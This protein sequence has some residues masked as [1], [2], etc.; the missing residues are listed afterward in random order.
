M[1]STIHFNHKALDLVFGRTAYPSRPSTLYFALFTIAPTAGGGGT[2]VTGGSY[3][4]KGMAANSTNFAVISG[5]SPLVNSVA[6]TF[7]LATVDWGTVVAWGIYDAA[8]AGNLLFYDAL[9]A[10]SLIV[11]G[12]RASIAASGISIS[13]VGH[14]SN[15]MNVSLLNH[16]FNSTA[17]P[18][19]TNHYYGLSISGVTA[20]GLT[21]ETSGSG[22][23]RALLANNKTNYGN[24]GAVEE[25]T[26]YNDVAVA[27]YSPIAA[28]SGGSVQAYF[29]IYSAVTGGNFIWGGAIGTPLSMTSGVGGYQFG[30][31]EI[32]LQ[33]TP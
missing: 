21:S 5:T 15:Y 8:T 25:N 7:P 22:Y 17:F 24:A 18:T 14:F 2:E 20:T 30:A 26:V 1:P 27:T 12:Q 19:I 32:A 13:M 9:A 28:W 10:S 33:L 11:A 23:A 29:G 31:G 16:I 6:I 4:R 3:A